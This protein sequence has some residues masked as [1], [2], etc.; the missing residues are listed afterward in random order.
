MPVMQK[1]QFTEYIIPSQEVLS[2][3]SGL[4]ASEGTEKER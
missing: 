3:R 4:P 2:A 1:V